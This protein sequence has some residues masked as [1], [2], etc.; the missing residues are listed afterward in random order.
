[1]VERA[2][3]HLISVTQ[4]QVPFSTE[5]RSLN[6]LGKKVGALRRGGAPEELNEAQLARV[7]NDGVANNDR[8]RGATHGLQLSK[9]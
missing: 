9:R 1:M 5:R 7:A 4:E 2:A 6:Q 3:R 8:A